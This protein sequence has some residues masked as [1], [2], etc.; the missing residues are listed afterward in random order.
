MNFLHTS[1][2]CAIIATFLYGI[3]A[4]VMKAAGNAGASPSGMAL[5]YGIGSI[6]VAI[7]MKGNSPMF[8]STSSII[9][10]IPI[11][12]ICGFAFLFVG[13]AFNLPG[14]N[15]GIITTLIAAHCIVATIGSAIFMGELAKIHLLR[16]V[17]GTILILLG[18][19]VVSTS[20]K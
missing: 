18:V 2:G 9:L 19:Y 8:Q 1:L 12:F 20:P 16:F 4:P 14:G 15:V 5:I 7:M 6:I 10:S 3:N 17:S 13:N 11:G